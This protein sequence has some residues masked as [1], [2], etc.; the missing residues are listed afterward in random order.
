MLCRIIS[1]RIWIIKMVMI[2]SFAKFLEFGNTM[3][4]SPG[5]TSFCLRLFCGSWV[6]FSPSG[7]R[8]CGHNRARCRRH[9]WGLQNKGQWDFLPPQLGQEG[10][11]MLG[12][13]RACLL[14]WVAAHLG[15]HPRPCW[16]LMGNVLFQAGFPVCS[17]HSWATSPFHK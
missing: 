6:L 14:L 7:H 10:I 17:V 5:E 8:P 2:S 12:L 13:T 15:Q 3:F 16:T 1:F 9:L 11:V 4:P